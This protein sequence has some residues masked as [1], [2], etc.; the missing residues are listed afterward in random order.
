M[1][2]ALICLALFAIVALVAALAVIAFAMLYITRVH[3]ATLA[4]AGGMYARSTELATSQHESGAKYSLTMVQVA[5][6]LTKSVDDA[7]RNRVRQINVAVN[8]R[9]V[10]TEIEPIED[11]P[12]PPVFQSGLLDDFHEIARE[13]NRVRRDDAEYAAREAGIGSQEI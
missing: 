1:Q 10:Q 6:K 3:E 11:A 2:A 9:S 5:E 7:V 13:N 8:P 4:A 12:P